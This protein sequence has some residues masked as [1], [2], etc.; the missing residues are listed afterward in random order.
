MFYDRDHHQNIGTVKNIIGKVVTTIV[1][2]SK[3]GLTDYS[4]KKVEFLQK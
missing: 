4:V 2:H 1:Y 3:D